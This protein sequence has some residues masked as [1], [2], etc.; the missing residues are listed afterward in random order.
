MAPFYIEF[1]VFRH[2]VMNFENTKEHF[3]NKKMIF[4]QNMNQF[5]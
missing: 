4:I 5:L 2:F 1:Q 3:K